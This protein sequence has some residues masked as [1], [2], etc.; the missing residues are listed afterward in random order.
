MWLNTS[1]GNRISGIVFFLSITNIFNFVSSTRQHNYSKKYFLTVIV[2]FPLML[3]VLL[4]TISIISEVSSIFSTYLAHLIISL[5]SFLK[6]FFENLIVYHVSVLLAFEKFISFNEESSLYTSISNK[7]L[8][9]F[10]FLYF[11]F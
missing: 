10:P 8:Q 3:I 7:L 11:F 9:N 4:S 5:L 2:L 1:D 6:I